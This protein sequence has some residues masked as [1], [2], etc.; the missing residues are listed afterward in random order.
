MVALAAHRVQLEVAS[1]TEIEIRIH[2]L[3]AL[4][5]ILDQWLA[6]QE[7]HDKADAR[8]Q[9]EEHDDRPERRTHAAS[10]SVTIHIA[11]HQHVETEKDADE[12][13]PEGDQGKRL[14]MWIQRQQYLER[15][16]L[17]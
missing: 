3:H 14:R 1:R 8:C 11:D 16:E 6:Q 2:P 9:Q 4:R 17:P 13:A 10:L 5:T 15:N 7:I 12:D